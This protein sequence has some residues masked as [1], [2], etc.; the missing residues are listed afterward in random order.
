MSKKRHKEAARKREAGGFVALPYVVL[1][2][3]EFS[4]LSPFA[5]KALMDLLSQY[6]GDNNGDLCAAWTLMSKR[7]WRSR[8]SLGKG[9]KDLTDADFILRTR[10]GGRHV[11]TLYAVTFYEV[12]W[13]GGKLDLE[14]PTRRFMGTWRKQPGVPNASASRSPVMISVSRPQDQ[15]TQIC[16]ADRVNSVASS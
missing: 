15:S 14:A 4:N 16:P 13:C 2:S 12:D 10:Q 1:R 5:V 8:D 7:G 9:L 11:A 6:R 3:L